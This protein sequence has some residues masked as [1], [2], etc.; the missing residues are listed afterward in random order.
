MQKKLLLIARCAFWNIEGFDDKTIKAR[1]AIKRMVQDHLLTEV[2]K[3]SVW[4]SNKH[5]HTQPPPPEVL[6][7]L[8][9]YGLASQSKVS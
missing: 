2:A 8:Q 7:T 1:N 4:L 3:A 5:N 9:Q 6:A